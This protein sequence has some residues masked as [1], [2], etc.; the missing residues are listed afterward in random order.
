MLYIDA[1]ARVGFSRMSGGRCHVPTV[2]RRLH[3]DGVAERAAAS[4]RERR[5]GDRVR[6]ELVQ[7]ADHGDHGAPP[8]L[9]V[10]AAGGWNDGLDG[11]GGRAGDGGGVERGRRQDDP[12]AGD[13]SRRRR[14]W[15]PADRQRRRVDR[16]PGN[17]LRRAAR[18]SAPAATAIRS[19]RRDSGVTSSS[20]APGGSPT[21]WLG[22][23]TCDQQVAGSNA[24]H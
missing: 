9:P 12:V 1:H 7:S 21:E 17:G 18:Y 14:R 2:L 19:C 3:D 24:G 11:R 20:T 8:P 13:R 16:S 10:R 5:H 22:Y 23:C 6:S 4:N 15:L